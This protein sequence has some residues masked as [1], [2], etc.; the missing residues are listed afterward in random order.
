MKK[1]I[2]VFI[3]LGTL[4]SAKAQLGIDFYPITSMVG[5]R[6]HPLAKTPDSTFH[7][8][9]WETNFKYHYELRSS[10]AYTFGS[11]GVLQSAQPEALSLFHIAGEIKNEPGL[12]G[13]FGAYVK[14]TN[15]RA[16]SWGIFFPLVMEY[17]PQFKSGDHLIFDAEMDLMVKAS[18]T[19]TLRLRPLLG[20]SWLF[21]SRKI[22][23]SRMTNHK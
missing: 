15:N 5:V 6:W 22:T 11:G 9:L 3:F 13:G 16:T 10:F 20:I 18:G 4:I 14:Y 19:P 8:T 12:M 7:K 17:A 23:E 1:T 2:L 21:D